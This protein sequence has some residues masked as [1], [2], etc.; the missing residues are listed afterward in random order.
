MCQV[1]YL[2]ETMFCYLILVPLTDMSRL[3]DYIIPSKEAIQISDHK[4]WI[5]RILSHLRYLHLPF[6]ELNI[7][8]QPVQLHHLFHRDSRCPPIEDT[9]IYLLKDLLL[10]KFFQLSKTSRSPCKICRDL[11]PNGNLKT[12]ILTLKLQFGPCTHILPP[13]YRRTTL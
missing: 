11:P 3:K 10:K 12:D 9:V 1:C 7:L 2:I 8:L 5:T 13:A 6:L 4:I